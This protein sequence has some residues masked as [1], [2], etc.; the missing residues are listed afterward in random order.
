MSSSSHTTPTTRSPHAIAQWKWRRRS[1]RYGGRTTEPALGTQRRIQALCANGWTFA[2]LSIHLG[3]EDRLAARGPLRSKRVLRETA[4]MIRKL[5]DELWDVPG[6]SVHTM[7]RAAARGWVGP[8]AWAGQDMDD[9]TARPF[10]KMV[11]T[12]NSLIYIDEI[13]V[14]R[15]MT[16]QLADPTED[17]LTEA[18]IRY[19]ERGVDPETAARFMNLD[20][21]VT[22]KIWRRMERG[23]TRYEHRPVARTA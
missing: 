18:C 4:D 19:R 10:T 23:R 6:C 11:T 5:Y 16:G 20:R 1:Q 7:R 12:E 2:D 9:P 15:L 13:A 14:E 22:L 3:Y 21:T 8:E 17:E